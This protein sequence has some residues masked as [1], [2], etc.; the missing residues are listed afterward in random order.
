KLHSFG[1]SFETSQG[2][3]HAGRLI[4]AGIQSGCTGVGLTD[5]D[6]AG[7][8]EPQTGSQNKLQLRRIDIAGVKNGHICFTETNALRM[9]TNTSFRRSHG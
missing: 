7:G 8:R 3:S 6:P 9:R 4:M 1:E 2:S 5:A